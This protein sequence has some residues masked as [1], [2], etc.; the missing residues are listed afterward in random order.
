MTGYDYMTGVM[1]TVILGMILV[2]FSLAIKPKSNRQL[3]NSMLAAKDREMSCKPVYS[4]TKRV[5]DFIIAVISILA[6]LPILLIT[7]LVLFCSGVKTLLRSTVILGPAGKYVS[8]YRFNI[9]NSEGEITQIG[10]A[11]RKSAIEEFPLLW[12]LLKGDL[13]LI[14]LSKIKQEYVK[15]VEFDDI[16]YKYVKPGIASVGAL[17]CSEEYSR[18]EID[19]LYVRARGLKLDILIYGY[20]MRRA[21][22]KE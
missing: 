9:Y 10:R 5:I 8:I 22:V 11:I 18:S 15:S 16:A 14:G 17:L 2:L 20:V 19:Q 13:S 12:S 1:Y 21:F 3:V 7:A 6:L 4:C